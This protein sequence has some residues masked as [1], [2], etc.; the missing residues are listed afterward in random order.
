MSLVVPQAGSSSVDSLAE[1]YGRW[2]IHGPQGFGKTVL[3]STIA[4]LGPTLYVDLTGEKGLRSIK[5]SPWAKNVV[6]VRPASITELDDLYWEVAKGGHPYRAIVL[7]SLT[8]AQKMAMRFMLGHDETA[9]KEIRR[10]VAPASYGTW[11]GT[12]DIM[13]DIATFWYGLADAQRPHPMHVVMTA[14]TKITEDEAEEGNIRRTPDVQ[15]G[16]LSIVLS[17]PDYIVY[18]DT[19][20]NSEYTGSYTDLTEGAVEGNPQQFTAPVTHIVRFGAQPEY[21]TKALV[22]YHLRGKIPPVLGRRAPTNL[23]HLSKVLGIGGTSVKAAP[24]RKPNPTQP[25]N[26]A[27]EGVP[28]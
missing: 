14:Q 12:L 18:V 10:G 3:A 20:A 22:P 4:G 19:E 16:A 26:T 9:V 21:R 28:A 27:K 25:S 8:S 13:T 24:P 15:K 2:L 7:D 5:G 1:D 17:A 23:A 11:G 6:P